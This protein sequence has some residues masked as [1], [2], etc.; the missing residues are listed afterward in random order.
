[1][2]ADP[3]ID[4]PEW[5]EWPLTFTPHVESRMEE[6]GFSE[7]ELRT[8]IAKVS[9]VTAARH[10]GRFVAMTQHAGEPWAVVLEPE[11]DDQL[12]FVVT[13]FRRDQL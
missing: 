6:R 1:M 5:W 13:G 11:W 3:R 2:D 12:L 4:A 10:P 9:R 7:V 8:M